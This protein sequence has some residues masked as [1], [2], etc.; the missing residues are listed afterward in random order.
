MEARV[1][2]SLEEFEESKDDLKKVLKLMA[3]NDIETMDS[4]ELATI[5]AVLKLM[6]TYTEV[7]KQQT[8]SIDLLHD[9]MNRLLSK[10]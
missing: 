2:K 8:E 7:I 3:S 9:K 1:R 4:K 5:Q 10:K 6:D